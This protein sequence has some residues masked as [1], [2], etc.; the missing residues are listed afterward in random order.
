MERMFKDR[1]DAGKQVAEKLKDEYKDKPDTIVIGLPRG[2]VIVAAQVADQLG[3][4][5]DIV[6]PRK[7]GAPFQPELA[8]GAITQD[9]ELVWNEHIMNMLHLKPKDLDETIKKETEEAQRRLKLYRGNRPPLELAGKT[10]ILVDDGIA[11]GA[12]MRA[13]IQY[14]KTHGALKIIVAVPVAAVDTLDALQWKVDEIISVIVPTAFYG[15]GGF[16]HSFPQTSD[17]EVID[18]MQSHRPI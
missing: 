9:G 8:V 17:Q 16:Y 14:A 18:I 5:L 11:T 13:T 10:V 6:V 15:V 1:I 7:I 4:P 2:G 12:T 3:L